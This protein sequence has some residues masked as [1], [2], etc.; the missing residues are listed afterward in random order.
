MTQPNEL[1]GTIT[2]GVLA[3][4]V[5]AIGLS[6][7]RWGNRHGQTTLR[8]FDRVAIG[9]TVD[10][11]IDLLGTHGRHMATSTESVNG[12]SVET[13]ECL[14]TNDDGSFCNVTF[15]N[16]HVARKTQIGCELVDR[17]LE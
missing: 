13:R 17:T 5:L 9:A 7:Y 3:W 11:C 12:V 1:I 10:Q 16:G 4:I 6:S 8:G 14:W 15:E 2:I